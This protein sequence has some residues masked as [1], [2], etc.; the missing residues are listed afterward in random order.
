MKS[1][2]SVISNGLAN[3]LTLHDLALIL[4]FLEPLKARNEK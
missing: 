3:N 2:T 4:P 1:E